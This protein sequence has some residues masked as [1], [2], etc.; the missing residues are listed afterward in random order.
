MKYLGVHVSDVKL[1]KAEL[2]E[3]NKVRNRLETWKCGS[4]YYG[5]KSIVL[6]TCLT[7]IPLL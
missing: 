3:K 6:N 4:L 5:G 7:I 1:T 2:S